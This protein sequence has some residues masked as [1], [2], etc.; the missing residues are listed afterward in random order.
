MKEFEEML[1]TLHP[2][3]EEKKLTPKQEQILK[4]AVEVFAEK[5]YASSSTSE[6]ASRANVAEGTIF[7]HYKTKKDLLIAIVKPFMRGFAVPFFAARFVQDVFDVPPEKLEDLLKTLIKNR[8]EFVKENAPLL[9][10]V[11]QELAFHSELKDQFQEVFIQEIFPKF[12][13]A[14]Y[15]LKEKGAVVDF[16]NPTMIRMIMSPII[17]FLVTRFLI[18]PDLPWDDEKELDQTVHFIMHGL[19]KGTGSSSD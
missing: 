15:H 13:E 8:F 12:E 17:G 10:I 6:I 11:L 4:A 19:S 7:R 3:S 14:I 18:A 5:G 9:K 16:P 1:H 2:P